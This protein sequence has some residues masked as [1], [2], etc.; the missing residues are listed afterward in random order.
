MHTAAA[1]DYLNHIDSNDSLN[2]I[3][4]SQS[5]AQRNIDDYRI[6]QISMVLDPDTG[7]ALL[8][9]RVNFLPES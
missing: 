8:R 2:H 3:D 9:Y 4:R 5:N 6:L 1:Y 7:L